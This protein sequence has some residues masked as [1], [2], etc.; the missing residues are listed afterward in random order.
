VERGPS[1]L[2]LPLAPSE[3]APFNTITPDFF[4]ALVLTHTCS[5]VGGVRKLSYRQWLNALALLSDESGRDLF[6]LITA[7]VELEH[8]HLLTEVQAVHQGAPPGSTTDSQFEKVSAASGNGNPQADADG[9]AQEGPVDGGSQQKLTGRLT[10]LERAI[11]D[12]E[13][14]L[15]AQQQD[16]GVR[17]STGRTPM[18]ARSTPANPMSQTVPGRSRPRTS[19]SGLVPTPNGTAV[20]SHAW[21]S[22][23]HMGSSPS[24]MRPPG[25]HTMAE[26]RARAGTTASPRG[27]PPNVM[28]A[29]MAR[30]MEEFKPLTAGDSSGGV[31]RSD[32]GP[33]GMA[34]GDSAARLA[35]GDGGGPL[36][37]RAS[38]DAVA[39]TGGGAGGTARS[40][41]SRAQSA[42]TSPMRPRTASP[43]GHY[44][45][46]ARLLERCGIE[47][48]VSRCSRTR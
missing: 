40:A 30:A 20:R 27:V 25:G 28:D 16:N 21:D 13:A 14:R 26:V 32:S 2:A 11:M 33:H 10:L 34:G 22:P 45:P 6:S 8:P 36:S 5:C 19:G 35:E 4:L 41:R 37:T 23:D 42:R 24:R 12:E 18:A 43:P 9:S 46:K 29:A 44:P 15:A 48:C 17:R 47:A 31:R 39:G 7:H 3:L 1:L 38:V